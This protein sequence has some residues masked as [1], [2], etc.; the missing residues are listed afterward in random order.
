MKTPHVTIAALFVVII[1]CSDSSAPP[2]PTGVVLGAPVA[3]TQYGNLGGGT[4]YPD[5][6]PAGQAVVGYHGFLTSPTGYH[7][8]IQAI[9]GTLM[10]TGASV[11]VALGDTLPL[12]GLLNNTEWTSACA[13]HQ[14][15]V[16]F[17]GRSG[18]LIDQLT[19]RCAPLV[20]SVQGDAYAIGLGATT[21]LAPVGGTGGTEFAQTDCTGAAIATVSDIRAGDGIDAFG[22]GCS[23]VTLVQP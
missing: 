15:V 23:A 22:M 1:A 6:C 20:L 5:A 13:S 11:Q 8:Q 14:V 12:R 21:D 16:G 10:L 4:A 2:L 3:T 17:R 18:A 7:G 9:C 19:I